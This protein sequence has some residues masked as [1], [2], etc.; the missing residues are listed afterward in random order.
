MRRFFVAALTVIGFFIVALPAFAQEP[1]QRDRH[2]G[3]Y[4]PTIKSRETYESRAQSLPDSDRQRRLSFVSLLS[5][6]QAERPYPPRY[7][8]FAKGEEAEKFILVGFENSGINTIYRARALFAAMTNLARLTPL[9][10]ELQVDDLFTF[11]DLL[12]L[13]GFTQITVS[14]GDKFTHQITLK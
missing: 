14:D 9:F 10:Q 5:Q 8:M 12:K 3:Y 13:L 1:R 4:Y 11:F 7:A 6:Q 2:E